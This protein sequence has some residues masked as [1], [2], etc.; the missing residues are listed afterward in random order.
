MKVCIKWIIVFVVFSSLSVYAT[1]QQ[2]GF[3]SF[4]ELPDGRISFLCQQ[5][6]VALLGSVANDDS[7][8]FA[9]TLNGQWTIW[10]GILINQQVYPVV[11]KQINGLSTLSDSYLFSDIPWWEQI[12]KDQAQVVLLVQGN[13]QSD[14]FSAT[15]S[16]LSFTDKITSRWHDFWSFE[17]LTPYSINLRYGVKMLGTSIV[18]YGY[19]I[20]ILWWLYVLF[21]QKYRHRKLQTF[22]YLSISI[23]LIIWIRN[24][25]TYIHITSDGLTQFTFQPPEQK[26]FFDLGDYIA[27]TEQIQQKIWLENQTNSSCSVFI[28]SFQGRP[29]TTHRGNFYLDPCIISQTWSEADYM[30]FYKKPINPLYSWATILVNYNGSTLLHK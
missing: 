24:L 11:T 10:Y 16:T 17:T 23:F 27:F 28:D 13:V 1:L 4:N 9:W 20:L 26:T 29:F 7:V 2:Q 19:I 6:C 14:A 5:Q 21:G 12:P 8:H 3:S 18:T 30:I 15:L 22:F 25:L